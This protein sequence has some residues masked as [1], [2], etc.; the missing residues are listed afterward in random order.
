MRRGVW[1]WL[2][3]F[4]VVAC[5]GSYAVPATTCDERCDLFVRACHQPY[6]PAECVAECEE[7]RRA[8]QFES[9]AAEYELLMDCLRPQPRVFCLSEADG[10]VCTAESDAYNICRNGGEEALARVSC[11]S[12][13]SYLAYPQDECP[14]EGNL[15]CEEDCVTRGLGRHSCREQHSAV[16]GCLFSQADPGGANPHL[17]TAWQDD[18]NASSPVP[19]WEERAALAACGA[20]EP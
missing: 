5:D 8:G 10:T 14:E 17:C 2:L 3:G 6:D 18:G 9:C 12:Y 20:G 15:A 4:G 1:W 11:R 13:C 19:C 16:V 7:S